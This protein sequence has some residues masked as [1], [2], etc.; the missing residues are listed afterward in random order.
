[1]TKWKMP[2]WMQEIYVELDISQFIKKDEANNRD[3]LSNEGVNAQG[4]IEALE[5][6]R[7]KKLLSTPTE[8]EANKN[9]IA[10]LKAKLD[11]AKHENT[12]AW[13]K[14]EKL[15]AENSELIN[16]NHSVAVCAEHTGDITLS[17]GLENG[18]LCCEIQKLKAEVE[19]LKGING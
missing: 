7:R 9:R 5:M 13:I 12:A 6:T 18:C 8:R 16:I 10:E 1:M 19:R 14:T 3:S 17:D 2:E 11:A 4:F 15:E